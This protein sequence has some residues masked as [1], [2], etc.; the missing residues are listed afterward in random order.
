M[1]YGAHQ[2][3]VPAARPNRWRTHGGGRDA[4]E[5]GRAAGWR[6]ESRVRAGSDPGGDGGGAGRALG[7]ADLPAHCSAGCRIAWRWRRSRRDGRCRSTRSKETCG[8][9]VDRYAEARAAFERAQKIDATA[10]VLVG[11]ARAGARLGDQAGACEAYRQAVGTAERALLDEAR[12]YLSAPPASDRYRY[13]PAILEALAG[14][15]LSLVRRHR[16]ASCATRST[17]STVT[18]SA[19]CATVAGPVSSQPVNWRRASSSCVSATCCCRFRSRTGRNERDSRIAGRA[20][21][22]PYRRK[23]RPVRRR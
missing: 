5:A 4:G 17:I 9:K 8:L 23:R 20:G 10:F 6:V 18:R 7:D 3:C 14:H 19:L 22:R 13:R 12:A 1:E 21:F 16:R 11:L 15:G 2:A